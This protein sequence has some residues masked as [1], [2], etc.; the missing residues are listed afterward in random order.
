MIIYRHTQ[1]VPQEMLIGFGLLGGVGTLMTPGGLKALVGL[2]VAG[3][4]A[5]FRCLTVE[6]SHSKISLEFGYWYNAIN[7]DVDNI[8]FCNPI[9]L[10]PLSGW[11][12]HYIGGGWLYNVYGL[13]AVEVVMR[14]G[15]RCYIGTDEPEL[16]SAAIKEAILRSSV[17]AAA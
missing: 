9:R 10:N 5:T 7:V 12:I 1:T 4:L 11:G 3:L 8:S 17:E 14:N 15:K 16:L 13:G 2:S 6:V